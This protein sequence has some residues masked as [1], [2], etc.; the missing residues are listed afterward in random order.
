MVKNRDQKNP[1]HKDDSVGLSEKTLGDDFDKKK[2]E[3]KPRDKASAQKE[4]QRKDKPEKARSDSANKNLKT[5]EVGTNRTDTKPEAKLSEKESVEESKIVEADVP[6]K[7]KLNKKRKTS[8][9]G[10]HPMPAIMR[11]L[12]AI[13]FLAI[14]AIFLT[15][16]VIWRTNMCE[17]DEAMTFIREKPA[18]AMYNYILFFALLAVASAV[19]WRPFFSTGLGFAI[20]SILTFIHMQKYSLRA[21]PFLPEE[22]GL[23]DAAGDL[24]QFVDI[25]SVWRLVAGVVFILIGS[26]LLEFYVR[27]LIGRNLQRRPLWDKVALIPRVTFSMMAIAML[28]M[29]VNPILHRKDTEWIEGLDLV[30]WNQIEN[31]EYNGF[32]IGFL[33]NLGNSEAEQPEEYN[34]ATMRELAKKY[35]AEKAADTTRLKLDEEVDN[36]VV[37]LEETFYDPALLTEYYDHYGGDVTPYLHAIFR[38]YPSGY[39]Y[40]PE[41]GGGTA[42]VEFEVQTGLSNFWAQTFPYVNRVSKMDSLLGVADWARSAGFKTTAVHSYNGS[43]YKRNIVYPRIGYDKFIDAEEMKYTDHDYESSVINDQSIYR[44]ILDLLESS[45]EP[46]MIGAVT[47]QNHAPYQQANYPKLEF[48]LKEPSPD[49]WAI[50]P[51]FQ[52]LHESDRYLGEFIEALDKL[53]EKTVVLWFGDHSMGLLNDYLSSGKKED[54]WTAHL[55]PYFIYA[56]FDIE[57]PYTVAETAE[58]NAAQ[59]LVYPTTIRG[60]DLPTTSPNCLQNTMYNI[61]NVEKP[62]LYYLVDKVC[63]TTPILTR[64]YYGSNTPTASEALR[65]YELVNYDVIN[66]KYYWDGK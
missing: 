10:K 9:R 35:Q 8:T 37:I 34:E 52:S 63:E 28:L 59:G 1:E 43:M 45:D 41:Y 60:I 51:S 65:E 22:L 31:Y 6:V 32:V 50:E 46:Q 26:I 29:I 11:V 33:Y 16:F 56:N 5:E 49:A 27:K 62:A 47:M 61:L 19:T 55:T 13:L 64:S 15:W 39:M 23:A 2:V 17:A 54:Q 40:S 21:E 7:R 14:V 12:C 58:M 53:D 48:P 4:S 38:K 18:L 57:S 20:A 36:I 42:N 66:G 3:K 30:A 44:E 24:I 25:D